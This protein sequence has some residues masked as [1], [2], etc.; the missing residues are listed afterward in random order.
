MYYHIAGPLA[1]LE[2][3][4]AV[5]DVQGLGYLIKIPLG[6][7]EAIKGATEAKLFIHYHTTEDS[8]TLYGFA[9]EEDRQIFQMLIS[10]S[11]VGPSIGLM[12]LS[13]M[14]SKEIATAIM[15]DN[16]AALTRIKGLGAKTAQRLTLELKGKMLKTSVMDPDNL[17]APATH[18]TERDDALL[19][20]VALGLQKAAAEK[21]LEAIMK[22]EPNL[23]AAE[24][25]RRALKR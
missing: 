15:T 3:T 25:I 14:R 7:Y 5:I 21:A 17:S 4:F 13:Q 8:Q 19:A 9:A 23:G 12:A 18:N 24:L 6:T 16:S 1:K 20:L 11:G 22:T 2:P 10:V